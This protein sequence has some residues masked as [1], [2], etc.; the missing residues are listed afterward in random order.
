[1]AKKQKQQETNN[2]TVQDQYLQTQGRYAG[3]T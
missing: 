2:A 3:A 1:M